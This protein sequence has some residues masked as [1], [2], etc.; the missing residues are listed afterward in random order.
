MKIN[1]LFYIEKLNT[2]NI[3]YNYYSFRLIIKNTLRD[4]VRMREGDNQKIM[5]LHPASALSSTL[6]YSLKHYTK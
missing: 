5:H 2:S 1:D 3:N 6:L 4:Y